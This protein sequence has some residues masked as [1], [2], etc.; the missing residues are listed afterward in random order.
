MRRPRSSSDNFICSLV[1]AGFRLFVFP[2]GIPARQSF[3]GR[4]E[5]GKSNRGCD[6]S[7]ETRGNG[8]REISP[9]RK[10]QKKKKRERRRAQRYGGLAFSVNVKWARVLSPAHFSASDP[11]RRSQR[12]KPNRRRETE[13]GISLVGLRRGRRVAC[14][15]AKIERA[16]ERERDREGEGGGER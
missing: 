2:T 14:R 5:R 15:C 4:R 3:A 10:W 13:R 6:P 7:S 12:G 1:S 11:R 9:G 16:G 8:T